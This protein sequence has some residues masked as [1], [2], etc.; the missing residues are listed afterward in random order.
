VARFL[1]ADWVDEFNSALAGVDLTGAAGDV[2]TTASARPFT[3]AQ[4]IADGP[5]GPIETLLRV[6]RDVTMALAGPASDGPPP[7]VTISLH[8]ED[9]V[10]LSR[11]Q[12]DPAT[13]LGAGRIRVR[14]DLSVLT[15]GQAVLA[16]A[17]PH[18]AALGAATTY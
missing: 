7:D 13:A 10:A 18:L 14:G 6:D 1:S 12:L 2:S 11:G 17:R 15:A 5:D 16:A 4:H 8:Y 3:V 9:A